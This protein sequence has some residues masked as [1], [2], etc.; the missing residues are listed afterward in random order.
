MLRIYPFD[1]R[2]GGPLHSHTPAPESTATVASFRIWRVYNLSSR[3]DRRGCPEVLSLPGGEV[4]VQGKLE[5]I[6]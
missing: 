5:K 6:C 2:N 4:G 1:R 3:G